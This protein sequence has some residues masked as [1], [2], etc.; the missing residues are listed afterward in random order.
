MAAPQMRK[1]SLEVAASQRK[2][3][4][5]RWNSLED[6]A[7]DGSDDEATERAKEQWYAEWY[8]SYSD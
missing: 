2:D 7:A 8:F 1:L 4:E 3:L 6:A 5:R